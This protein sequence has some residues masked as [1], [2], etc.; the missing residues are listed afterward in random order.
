MKGSYLND[1]FFSRL[2]T[3]ALELV[4]VLLNDYSGLLEARYKVEEISN[5]GLEAMEQIG[6]KRGFLFSGG[7]IDYE[8]TARTILDEFRSGKTGR[9]TLEKADRK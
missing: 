4:K 1:A 7:R 8:R 5:D 6:R 2:E 3:L 9:I